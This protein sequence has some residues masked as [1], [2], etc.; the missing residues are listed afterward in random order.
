[1]AIATATMS[2]KQA[3]PYRRKKVRIVSRRRRRIENALVAYSFIAP[4]F[5]GFAIFTLGPIL[6][7]FVLAFM[8][9]DGSNPMR[10]AGLDNFWRLFEDK[11]FIAALWNTVIY[12]VA[13]VPA[14]LACALGLAILLNQKILG[15]N[16]FRTAMFFPYVASLV[17]VAVVW[18]MI[19]NPEMGPVN[20]LLYTLG[21]DPADMPGWAADR[22]WAMVT[23]ILF[24]VWKSMGYYM[25][26]YLAGLQ[27]I[28]SELYEAA[29][30]D[31]AN[32]WQK[33]IHVTLPQLA[34]TTF[35]VTVMLTIQS[36]KVFDQ[37]YMITQGGPGTSTLVLVYHIY[38][39]AFISW[40]LGYS[41][42]IALVLFFLVLIV[43]IVQFKRQRED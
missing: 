22:H 28:N 34:P 4:N 25:V 41:S 13:S 42:M 31:G 3:A 9:W 40:D 23:V 21:L 20:M 16:F 11:A 18:N 8:H 39:E 36:F 14:T 10:F 24:G 38:N 30:L 7:A 37:V 6:F 5:L 26:I 29:G 1:M 33:F 2:D 32:S 35:F 43:T 17:A 15:R 27:G 19:F 12:T